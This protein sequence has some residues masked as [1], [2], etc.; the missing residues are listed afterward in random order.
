MLKN[1]SLFKCSVVFLLLSVSMGWS[2]NL[3]ATGNQ[4]YCPKSDIHIVTDFTITNPDN[5]AIDAVYIQVSLG[6]VQGED[7]LTLDGIHP[8]V[9]AQWVPSEGKLTLNRNTATVPYTDLVT[10]VKNVLF[11]S[12]SNNP[13]NKEF[14]IT[15]GD[16]NYLPSTGHYYQYIPDLAITWSNA[17][18]A[19]AAK[20]Y[21]GL[22]GYLATLTSAEEAQLCG[23]QAAGAGWI[24]G[25]DEEVEGTWKWVTGPESGTVFWYGNGNGY[26]PN[27]AF[28]NT[29]EP[30]QS[31]DEDYAHITAPGVGIPGSWNDLSNTGSLI[32]GNNYQPK[33]YIVE[34]GGLPGDPILNIATSSK[35]YTASIINT[36]ADAICD[37]GMVTLEATVSQGVTAAWFH[38]STGGSILYEGA[39]FQPNV[40]GTTTYYVGIK[41]CA[42]I[43]RKAVVATVTTT[44]T[45]V[46]VTDGVACGSG[47]GTLFASASQGTINWYDAP[48]G[49]VSLH[50]GA[51]FTVS[52]LS[53]TKIYYVDA[54]LNNCTSPN[55]T[56]VTLTVNS[57]P[58]FEVTGTTVYCTGTAPIV[59]QVI[60]PKDHYSYEWKN[61]KGEIIGSAMSVEVSGGDT[62]S[63][64]ATS[65]QL[66]SS[67]PKTVLAQ[68][69]DKA[70]ISL[71]DVTIIENSDNNT[72][73][74]NNQNNNLGPG[75][76]EFAL[77]AFDGPYKDE[78][79]FNNVVAGLHVVYVKDKNGCG[80]S[81]LNVFVLGF[82]RFFTPNND[83]VNDT[84]QVKGVDVN[85]SNASNVTIYDRYGK[86][87]K[88]INAK[89]GV[90]DG[91]FNGQ[92]LGGADYWFV[93]QLKDAAGAI[94]TY[95]GHFSLV[96]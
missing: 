44:P 25:S 88:Q 79:I 49:G 81:Q 7:V 30:N 32:N 15:I 67:A 23:K 31:G 95:R 26:S 4:L 16:A 6:Y 60:N 37:G 78:P 36:T 76:Y 21:F 34:Y 22:Q 73:I 41:E 61:S 39:V 65:N 45:I 70:R 13:I 40:M 50:T 33:G 69:S 87:I 82:P 57:A 51:S 75:N 9:T 89:N 46:D 86:L 54:T 20:T 1:I 27:F 38:V 84:W 64:V 96:R 93:A 59:L 19:A 63:V 42:N 94:K 56:P 14:S 68:E 53:A 77:D 85:F 29:S 10:A 5:T 3:T 92:P 12:T 35:I 8:N 18:I 72:I 11:N 62:Y 52:G 28:W 83:G 43:E 66:C 47:P 24:G 48:T 74:I 58:E 2:Q 80:V 17:R 55:R 91:T 90:W 71:E